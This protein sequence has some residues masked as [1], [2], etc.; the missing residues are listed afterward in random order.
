MTIT[1][2]VSLLK[3]GTMIVMGNVNAK[4]DSD[5]ILPGHVMERH[6]LG[7]RNNG[8]RYAGFYDID[9]LITGGTMFEIGSA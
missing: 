4:V 8:E 5:M 9:C 3:A 7:D 6:G 2:Y 1:G